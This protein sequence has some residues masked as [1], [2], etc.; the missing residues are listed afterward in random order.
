MAEALRRVAGD[1]AIIPGEAVGLK[2]SKGSRVAG[3]VAV[4]IPREAELPPVAASVERSGET[5]L[6]EQVKQGN[7][8]GE[9]V[10]HCGVLSGFL[11]LSLT[12][13]H[14]DYKR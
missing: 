5:A 7:D 4:L 12:S 3:D 13:L 10:I 1:V 8:G 2:L 14:L 9:V 6:G 11:V